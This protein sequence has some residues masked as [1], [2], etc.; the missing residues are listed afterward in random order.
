MAEKR[1]FA[2]T[3]VLSDDFLD[4]PMSARCLY[5][6]LNMVA[7][8]DGF[9]NAPKGVM[10]QCGCSLDDMKILV[11]KSFVIPFESGVVVIRHWRI[12]NILKSDRYNPTK[13]VAEK[14]LLETDKTGAYQKVEPQISIGKNREGN[15]YIHQTPTDFDAEFDRIWSIYPRKEGKK[16][17]LASYIRDRKKGAT[18][19]EIE[20]GVRKYKNHILA[21][22]TEKRFIMQGSTFFNGQ[23][24]K[25]EYEDKQEYGEFY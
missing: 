16:N 20:E 4:M 24:W 1:M 25:D 3:I 5:F 7:D 18:A 9:V 21:E 22:R 14:E 19:E 2:K 13:C 8:D 10:R 17:A 6:T 23:R 12:N 15:I 11:A